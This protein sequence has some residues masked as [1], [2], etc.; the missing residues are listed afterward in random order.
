M[1]VNLISLWGLEVAVALGLSQGLGWGI[2]GVWWGRTL[3][4]LANGSLLGLWFRRGRWK[5]KD[6]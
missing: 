2:A 3:A 1:A 5:H 4:N 6:V